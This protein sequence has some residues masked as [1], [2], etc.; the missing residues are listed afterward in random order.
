MKNTNHKHKLKELNSKMNLFLIFPL[1]REFSKSY[2]G[3]VAAAR[4]YS[5]G[6]PQNLPCRCLT[7]YPY[8]IP[9]IRYPK[10]SASSSKTILARM[11]TEDEALSSRPR[12]VNRSFLAAS[13]AE[14]SGELSEEEAG[15][16]DGLFETGQILKVSVH[17]FMCHRKF[18]GEFVLLPHPS[19]CHL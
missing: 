16:G 19:H 11:A 8:P 9:V 18:T 3:P 12:R 4:H 7:T 14:D 10:E 1:P 17:E 13:Q 5:A 6:Q 15:P 2:S